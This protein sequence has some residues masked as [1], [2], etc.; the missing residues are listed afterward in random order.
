MQLPISVH[1][2]LVL[3]RNPR[4]RWSQHAELRAAQVSPAGRGNPSQETPL[5]CPRGQSLDPHSVCEYNRRETSN[6][7]SRNCCGST[8]PLGKSM[9]EFTQPSTQLPPAPFLLPSCSSHPTSPMETLPYP[10]TDRKNHPK[11]RAVCF[12]LFYR[13]K[14][15]HGCF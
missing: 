15:C 4:L 5:T 7:E 1:R 11:T 10:Q 2:A 3:C 14:T 8:A 13:N 9:L 6:T 12:G